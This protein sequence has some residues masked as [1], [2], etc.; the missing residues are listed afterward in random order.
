MPAATKQKHDIEVRVYPLK[1]PKGKIVAN[2]SATVN[3]MGVIGI[4]IID[5]QKGL[6]A[7]MPQTKIGEEYKDTSFPTT[8]DLRLAL[9]KKLVDTFVSERDKVS[10]K[11][12]IKEGQSAAK[13]AP[14]KGAAGKGKGT[15]KSE[16]AH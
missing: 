8:R 7:Q 11:D 16:Q 4:R 12:T 2:A 14:A 5:G 3:G 13:D 15:K 1:E 6:F 9:N 10:V